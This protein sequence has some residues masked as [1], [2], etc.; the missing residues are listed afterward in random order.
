[1]NKVV[2]G[3]TDGRV[4]EKEGERREEESGSKERGRGRVRRS[5]KEQWNF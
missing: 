1:M 2:G 5:Q 3:K 4:G